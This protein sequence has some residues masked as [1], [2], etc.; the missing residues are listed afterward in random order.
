[1]DDAQAVSVP[2]D[3][4]VVLEPVKKDEENENSSPYREAVGSLMFLSV[5]SRPDISYAVNSVAKF[6]ENHN[7]IHWRS[8]KRVFAYLNGTRDLGIVYRNG[9]KDSSLVGYSDA[10]YAGDL[11]TR[12]STKGYAFNFVNGLVTWSSQRQKMATLSTTESEYV[13]Y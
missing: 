13:T 3:P 8:V 10:D 6:L 11:E 5:V 1:M 2:A 12:R 7:E 9:G 4:H